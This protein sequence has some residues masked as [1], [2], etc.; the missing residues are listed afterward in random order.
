M[1]SYKLGVIV[2]GQNPYPGQLIPVLGACFSQRDNTDSTP[3]TRLFSRHFEDTIAAEKLVRH[4]W[5]LLSR[6]KAF[7]NA[8]YLPAEMGG[9]S[10]DV[11]CLLRISRTVEFLFYC[12]VSRPLSPRKLKVMCAGNLA[13]YCGSLLA[14]RLRAVGVPV[15]QMNFRQPAF[16]DR[17]EFNRHLIGVDN[18][19][20][21]CEGNSLIA[22]QTMVREYLELG[23]PK[24]VSIVRLAISNMSKQNISPMT[25]KALESIA[26]QCKA[27]EQRLDV[28]TKDIKNLADADNVIKDM[29][30]TIRDLSTCVS[31]MA[32]LLLGD[33][34]T[35]KVII[36]AESSQVP[37]ASREQHASGIVEGGSEVTSVDLSTLSSAQP[38][39]ARTQSKP[40]ATANMFKV[41]KSPSVPRS[42]T[43]S[44]P[45]LQVKASASSSKRDPASGATT[46]LFGNTPFK[47][48]LETP[49]HGN[50]SDQSN[51]KRAPS[52]DQE[53]HDVDMDIVNDLL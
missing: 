10:S 23:E 21:F 8:D 35:Y 39:T 5:A 27:V 18:R 36:E 14:R 32:N 29:K 22:F 33:A 6:G 43:K 38:N 48:L 17:V 37:V 44:P 47:N 40:K 25:K 15:E 31:D 3:T 19:Y 13:N 9:G 20:T 28:A 42:T 26:G 4:T 45:P 34:Y 16:L 1:L 24:V 2:V 7:I 12:I 51:S 41:K 46:P 49:Q 11:D 30:N 52:P 53:V 50:K